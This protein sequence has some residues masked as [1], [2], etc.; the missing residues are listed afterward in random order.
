L[1]KPHNTYILPLYCFGNIIIEWAVPKIEV[2]EQPR[3]AH[4]RQEK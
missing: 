4:V 3:I 1:G 2:L